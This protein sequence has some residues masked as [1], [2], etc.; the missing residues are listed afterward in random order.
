MI[1]YKIKYSTIYTGTSR[2]LGRWIKP[3][4]MI[5]NIPKRDIEYPNL[6]IHDKV[7]KE[8]KGKDFTWWRVKPKKI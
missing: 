4:T 6:I 7:A 8:V 1:K 3:K 2:K 5:V